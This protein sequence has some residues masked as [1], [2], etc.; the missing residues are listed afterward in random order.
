MLVLVHRKDETRRL[1]NAIVRRQ[2]PMIYDPV[3]TGLKGNQ[4]L[5]FGG[6]HSNERV[7]F[8][9][10]NTRA[11]HRVNL[12]THSEPG[13]L[14][15]NINA[16]NYP[17]AHPASKAILKHAHAAAFADQFH[18]RVVVARSVPEM[19]SAGDTKRKASGF[20]PYSV[21]RRKLRDGRLGDIARMIINRQEESPRISFVLTRTIDKAVG[22]RAVRRG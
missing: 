3:S 4:F 11:G 2:S 17:P 7:A 5:R 18:D 1:E 12:P 21:G 8:G 19:I 22:K 14:Q 9:Y 13:K 15:S 6:S 16:T 20:P 10:T